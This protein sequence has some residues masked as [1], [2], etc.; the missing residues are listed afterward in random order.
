MAETEGIK[1]DALGDKHAAALD[2]ESLQRKKYK[3]SEL[4]ISQEQ[5]TSMQNM[6]VAFKKKGSF[7]SYRKKIWQDFYDL[8]GKTE[9]TAALEQL[10][11][12]E[13]EREPA[14]L[15]R[16]RGKAAT[17]IEGA[18]DRSDIYKNLENSFDKFVAGHLEPMLAAVRDIRRQEV[19]EETIAKEEAGGNMTE[20][21][22][23]RWRNERRA[24]RDKI[25][26]A[27]VEEQERIDAEK[28]KLRLEETR[29]RREIE[30]RKE[31]EQRER[32]EKR[33]A[34][35]RALEEQREKER[36]ERYD[37]RRRD[38]SRDRDRD[39][40]RSYDLPRGY[41]RYEGSGASSRYRDRERTVSRPTTP[42]A[43]T[44]VPAPPPVDEKTL[45]E[46]ALQLL[47]KEGEELAAKKKQK[48]EFDFEEAEAIESED[49][50]AARD[51]VK[52]ARLYTSVTADISPEKDLYEFVTVTTINITE[53]NVVATGMSN[54]PAAVLLRA[55][56]EPAVGKGKE[57]EKEKRSAIKIEIET[58]IVIV[59]VI[60]IFVNEDMIATLVVTETA[61]ATGNNLTT[62][63]KIDLETEIKTETEIVTVIFALVQGPIGSGPDLARPLEDGQ[64][65]GGDHALLVSWTL[66][67]TFHLPAIAVDPHAGVSD[68]LLVAKGNGMGIGIGIGSEIVTETVSVSVI[69]IV[70]GT[71]NLEMIGMTGMFLALEVT[72]IAKGINQSTEIE[73][74]TVIAKERGSGI[75][76]EKGIETETAIGIGIETGMNEEAVIAGA[77]VGEQP[78]PRLCLDNLYLYQDINIKLPSSYT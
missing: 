73:T 21:D 4:P 63:T 31:E 51:L 62:E 16:D 59:I 69:V 54:V 14:H 13:I 48:P 76:R 68:L 72:G 38:D 67:A 19:D 18:V 1:E 78:E 3:T 9:F 74:G 25:H 40:Y 23:D 58:V 37:H 53:T 71:E 36:Q 55:R 52:G 34:E 15:S 47:L 45:E 56:I 57:K 50:K 66:T 43:T 64:L 65:L 17:L 44:P 32:D 12:K 7:D 46:A 22:Y 42:K 8:E 35:Q 29:K 20:Q 61:V 27:E 5:Q 10:A 26:Q 28:E 49:E 11:E 33:R 75:G 6:L 39:R 30:R 77:E 24:E 60:I 2:V 70:I 41:D